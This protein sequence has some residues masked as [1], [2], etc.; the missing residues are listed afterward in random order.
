[1]RSWIGHALAGSARLACDCDRFLGNCARTCPL[2]IRVRG[3]DVAERI[4][5]VE[6]DLSTWTPQHAHFDLVLSLYVH[7]SDS[8][9]AMVQRLAAGVAPGGTL[10]MVGHRPIDPSTGAETP[11]AGQLQVSIDAATAALDPNRWRF[12]IAE[13]RLRPQVGTGVDAVILARK[14]SSRLAFLVG[15]G[16]PD[17]LGDGQ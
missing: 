1:M 9:E 12:H 4:D 16:S 5:W 6:G 13:D 2:D 14:Q 17:V 3:R 8:V 15:T 10:F 7:V 11:A